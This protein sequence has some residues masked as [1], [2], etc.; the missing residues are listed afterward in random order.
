[1][2]SAA[3][4]D[5]DERETLA[6]KPTART[7][8]PASTAERADSPKPDFS[9]DGAISRKVSVNKYKIVEYSYLHRLLAILQEQ[10][11]TARHVPA[12]P[13]P[14]HLSRTFALFLPQQRTRASRTA[15]T[16][17]PSKRV[18]VL[19]GLL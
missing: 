2:R 16:L 9:Q 14:V 4:K 11:I 13:T 5:T 6:T 15:F 3:P 7:E 17:L 12:T 10:Q 18:S 19:P 8:P 1:L